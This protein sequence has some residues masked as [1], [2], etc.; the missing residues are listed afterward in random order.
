MLAHRKIASVTVLDPGADLKF[1]VLVAP[2][3]IPGITIE[4]GWAFVSKS[5]SGSTANY[6]SFTLLNGGTA[7]TATTSIGGTAGGTSGMTAYVPE[8]IA[9]TAGS[10]RLTAGQVLMCNYDETGTVDPDAVSIVVEY[11]EGL[12]AARN[13]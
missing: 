13:S 12:G 4:K 7:G 8:A 6:V 5:I 11:V 9:I 1:P 3:D 10:G 2:A